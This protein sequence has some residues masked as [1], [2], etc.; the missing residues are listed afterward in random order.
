MRALAFLLVF[1]SGGA[2]ALESGAPLPPLSAPALGDP[3]H[4]VAFGDTKGSVVYV[5]FW[6]SWCAPCRQSMPLLQSL[7][8]R[9]GARGLRVIGVNKDVSVADAHRFLRTV[10]V[11]FTLVQDAGDALAHAFDVKAMPSGYLADRH[12]VVR[13]VHRGFTAE[14]GAALEREILSLLDETR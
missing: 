2:W 8:Q 1:A 11:D 7:Q 3:A 10:P 12:G 4:K 5:D 6:A 9:Y 13:F 14:S